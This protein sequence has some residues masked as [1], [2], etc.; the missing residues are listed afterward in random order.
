MGSAVSSASSKSS[1]VAMSIGAI[2][3]REKTYN[4]S[5][6]ELVVVAIL[7]VHCGADGLCT[8][9]VQCRASR[10]KRRAWV[11][12]EPVGLAVSGLGASVVSV[13]SRRL[14]DNHGILLLSTRPLSRLA[15]S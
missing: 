2:G 11:Q 1:C 6:R 4:F 5:V 12:N 14:W 7:V 9:Q 8:M 10:W 15:D 13:G 3:A